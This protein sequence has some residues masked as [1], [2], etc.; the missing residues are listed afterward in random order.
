MWRKVLSLFIH[1]PELLLNHLE[2]YAAQA[3][4]ELHAAR[5]RYLR[6]LA[7]LAL[8]SFTL[9]LSFVL[10]AFAGMLDL[11][12]TLDNRFWVYGLP[13]ALASLS[14]AALYYFQSGLNRQPASP[15]REQLRADFELLKSAAR[16]A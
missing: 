7:G 16:K 8:S 15:L 2:A 5:G 13:I 6:S 14:A 1:K 11:A 9:A 3:A 12:L 10:L 4:Q